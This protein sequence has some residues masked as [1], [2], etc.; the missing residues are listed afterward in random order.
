[1]P[2]L[3]LLLSLYQDLLA[4]YSIYGSSQ[5]VGRDTLISL[6]ER[7]EQAAVDKHFRSLACWLLL[8]AI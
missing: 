5:R 1:M 8:M 7:S 2:A 3:S 4:L 6:E